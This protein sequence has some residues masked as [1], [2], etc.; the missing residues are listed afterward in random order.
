MRVSYA[1][2]VKIALIATGGALGA[3]VRAGLGGLILA[4]FGHAPL[5][6]LAANLIGCALMGAAKGA[7]ELHQWGSPELRALVFA[8]FL[9]ALT[10]FSTF[11]A[12]GV[13]LWQSGQRALSIFYVT[14]SVLG[15]LASFGLGWWLVSRLGGP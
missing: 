14:G 1:L 9:G 15:G 7:V 13:A 10:T 6:T 8:G 5:G 2:G 3:L 12:D 11:E 4:R